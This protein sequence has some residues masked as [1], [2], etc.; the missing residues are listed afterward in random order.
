M[1]SIKICRLL[2]LWK[3]PNQLDIAIRPNKLYILRCNKRNF[4]SLFYQRIWKYSHIC[5]HT[6]FW[7]SLKDP[8]ILSWIRP[9]WIS[10]FPYYPSSTDISGGLRIIPH[11]KEEMEA[12]SIPP[13]YTHYCI[14]YQQWGKPHNSLL[15]II[16]TIISRKEATTEIG[17]SIHH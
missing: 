9:C 14:R 6:I 7:N 4:F 11:L 15:G 17:R 2:I 3:L 10:F 8:T 16:I 5:L 1:A 12:N 13:P